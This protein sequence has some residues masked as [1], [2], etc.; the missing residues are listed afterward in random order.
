MQRVT[1]ERGSRFL[2][3][4]L[5]GTRLSRAIHD[6]LAGRDVDAVDCS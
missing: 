5:A 4:I 1:R 6:D 3:V 2:V